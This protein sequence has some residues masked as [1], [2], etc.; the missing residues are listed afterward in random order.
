MSI[1]LNLL[2]FSAFI[3][4]FWNHFIINRKKLLIGIVLL[5]LLATFI[6][7]I[8]S[9]FAQNE[10]LDGLLNIVGGGI[11][12]LAFWLSTTALIIWKNAKEKTTQ[13]TFLD[14]LQVLPLLLI[15]LLIWFWIS[16]ASFKI[17]G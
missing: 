6:V 16:N 1:I 11:S 15:P 13:R 8:I 14:L 9:I 17:G 12:I 3:W 4:W 7:F 5:F 10:Y 2:I